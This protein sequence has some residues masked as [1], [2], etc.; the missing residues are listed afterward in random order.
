NAIEIGS[1]PQSNVM[2]PPI[3]SAI[4]NAACVQLAAVPSPTTWSGLDTSTNV[5]GTSHVGGGDGGG[6][7]A[8]R[9]GTKPSRGAVAPSVPLVPPSL[10]PGVSHAIAESATAITHPARVMSPAY[11]SAAEPVTERPPSSLF[12][13]AR[14]FDRGVARPDR[15]A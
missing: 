10:P 3:A 13:L 11:R 7:P 8:S 1:G 5:A 4:P 9:R 15:L 12:R 6:G 2:T 14:P